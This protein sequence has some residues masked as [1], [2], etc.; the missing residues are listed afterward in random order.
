MRRSKEA[1]GKT[2]ADIVE[3][4]SRLFRARGVDAV[5]VADVMG[6]LG[7]TVG[8]FYRHFESKDALVAEALEVASVQTAEAIESAL[9]GAPARTLGELVRFYLA[10][11]HRANPESGCPV[12]AL[13]SEAP[14]LGSRPREA[15]GAA[16][17]RLVGAVE[18][19]VRGA[20]ARRRAEALHAVAAM[21]GALVLSRATPDGAL[22][23]E[24]AAA[25]QEALRGGG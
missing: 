18:K 3:T 14:H 5:S 19:E 21:V 16:L 12:A 17:G 13:A 24:I 10:P 22:G 11:T 23:D 15:F 20:P 6:E 7:L 1:A 9:A 4:A 8:G 25:V 2:R